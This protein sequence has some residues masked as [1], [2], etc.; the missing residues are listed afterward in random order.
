MKKHILILVMSLSY[1]LNSFSQVG[2][3]IN[4]STSDEFYKKVT[5]YE[6]ING[7]I[8]PLAESKVI[9]QKFA[10]KFYPS[11]DGLYFLGRSDNQAISYGH[12]FYGRDGEILNI[13]IGK[14]SSNL[15]LKNSEENKTVFELNTLLKDL[16]ESTQLGTRKTYQEIFPLIENLN[17]QIK[18]LK[19][20]SKNKLFIED[21]DIIKDY[22]F[23]FYALHF[24]YSP[25]SKH[26]SAEEI[27]PFLNTIDQKYYLN[28]NLLK[29]PFGDNFM[30]MLITDAYINKKID[31]SNPTSRLSNSLI[32]IPNDVIKGQYLVNQAKLFK[33]Y[34][35]Y[36]KAV[37]PNKQYITLEDQETRLMQRL[38]ELADSKPGNEFIDFKFVDINGKE[39]SKASFAGK[40]VVFDFWATWCGP[41]KQEEPYFEKLAEEYE[42]K[43]VEFVAISTD[44]DK[45]A[46]ENY[47]KPKMGHFKGIHLHAGNNNILSEAYK[48]NTIP[49]YIL[50]DKKGNIITT[51]SPRPSNLELK[52][53]I[54][55]NI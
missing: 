34:D 5:L 23:K 12:I 18:S 3:V 19:T 16:R 39:F 29:L 52:T 32:F 41:C 51:N 42:G 45:K 14:D 15:E 17:S 48:I 33:S 7:R 28:E 11:Y 44:K 49:R 46:W 22:L 13:N 43:P 4:G 31:L 54:D 6:V 21:F 8:E 47:V 9:D 2:M 24:R 50:I 36:Q 1:M 40:I 53:L 26:P 20:K 37:E 27:I 55:S 25:K 35:E 38:T 10:F 30:T